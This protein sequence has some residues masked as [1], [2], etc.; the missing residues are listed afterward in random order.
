MACKM[1]T[2][3]SFLGEEV[4]SRHHAESKEKVLKASLL[5]TSGFGELFCRLQGFL[6]SF[7]FI[8]GRF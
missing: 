4:N 6:F 7:S 2:A 3:C 1:E 5:S 8:S